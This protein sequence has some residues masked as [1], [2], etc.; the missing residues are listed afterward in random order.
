MTIL[1]VAQKRITGTHTKYKEKDPYLNQKEI[2]T[3]ISF[4]S[5]NC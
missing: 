2:E 5:Y 3:K 1:L 4:F